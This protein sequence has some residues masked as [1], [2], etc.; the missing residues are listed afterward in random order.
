MSCGFDLPG[1][2]AD[3]IIAA[4]SVVQRIPLVTRDRHLLRSKRVPLAATR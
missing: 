2:P 1:D 3:Q 4:T